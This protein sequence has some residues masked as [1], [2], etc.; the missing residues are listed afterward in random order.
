MPFMPTLV[1]DNTYA[2]TVMIAEKCAKMILE[3]MAT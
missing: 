2:P 3:D 1:S